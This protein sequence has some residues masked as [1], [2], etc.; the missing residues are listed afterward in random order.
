[1][2]KRD[3]D[4]D[5]V[6]SEDNLIRAWDHVRYDAG[7]DYA[8]DIFGYDDVGLNINELIKTI[9]DILSFDNYQASSLKHV[10]VPKSILAV[11]PGSVPEIKDRIVSYAIINIIAPKIDSK[12][13]DS[14]YSYRVKKDYEKS[15]SGLF[16]K[17]IEI[18]YLKKKTL[19]RVALIE[20]WQYA[21]PV[22]Y[23]VSKHLYEVEGYNFLSVSD[24]SSYFENINHELLRDHLL[25]LLPNEQKTINLLMEILDRWVWKSGTMRRLG[26]GI[27]QRNDA[28]S[29]LGNIFL[30][31][32][33][34]ELE[35]YSK[36]HDIKYIRYMDD[37]QVFSK[38][39]DVAQE[40][41]LVM[42][43]AL[44]DLYLNVQG[45]K[46]QLL[47][48]KEIEKELFSPGMDELNETLNKIVDASRKGGLSPKEKNGFE[49][50]LKRH[51]TKISRKRKW[52]KHDWRL[53]ARLLTGFTLIE[54]NALVKN[55]LKVIE[56]NPDERINT[57]I[58]KYL[59][60]FPS[61]K[62]IIHG[63]KGFLLSSIDKFEYQEA[64]L[65]LLYGYL[66]EIPEQIFNLMKAIA[67]NRDND[68]FNRCAA[69]VAI[70]STKLDSE[71]LT[72]LLDLYDKETNV[73]VK[74]SI[75]LCLVQ[76]DLNS[77]KISIRKLNGEFDSH[78]TSVGKYYSKIL[79]NKDNFALKLIS[80][81][82]AISPHTNF[83]KEHFY[84]FYLL[85]KVNKKAVKEELAKLLKE[86]YDE[87]KGGEV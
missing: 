11:R 51:F 20:D 25:F 55:G 27:P 56:Q 14:V 5:K 70:G 12:F 64:Q 80:T 77:S 35:E 84:V 8:L 62:Q 71:M 15:K 29:F 10:E 44:R 76:F 87:I 54:S 36:S 59:S 4:Y 82:K 24:I 3:V 22:F 65:F 43:K 81:M 75:A 18:P 21:W 17:R 66:D 47:E 32:L 16:D 50:E 74:R 26:R 57:K 30:M 68:W 67:F 2:A 39:S 37:V 28:S 19:Q 48:G 6:I 58:I 45:S 38:S 46:T 86:N 61:D 79:F 78:L 1:M 73:E 85:I 69:L 49:K 53:F 41:L 7:D 83:Y 60:I 33:D 13:S 31:P 23:E 9:H 72:S 40:V 42:N 34:D 52:K 63:L